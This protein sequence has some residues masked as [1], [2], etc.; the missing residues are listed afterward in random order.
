MDVMLSLVLLA[1][2]P[3]KA[4]IDEQAVMAAFTA[5]QA[6][7]N[8]EI[9]SHP[10]INGSCKPLIR[11]ANASNRAAFAVRCTA[12]SRGIPSR[13]FHHRSASIESSRRCH[14]GQLSRSIDVYR[15]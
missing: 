1:V 14:D 3:G 15:L 4:G 13:S 8:F 6:P 12:T 7:T 9:Y 5:C 11:L 2:P 10:I